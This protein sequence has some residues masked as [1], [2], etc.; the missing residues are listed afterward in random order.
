M[1]VGCAH[2]L[3][4]R[5]LLGTPLLDFTGQYVLAAKLT[6]LFY[7]NCPASYFDAGKNQALIMPRDRDHPSRY[8]PEHWPDVG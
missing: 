7:C 4:V 6:S 8:E 2:Q 5:A 1:E 3:S